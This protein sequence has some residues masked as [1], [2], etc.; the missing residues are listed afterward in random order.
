MRRGVHIGRLPGV[1]YLLAEPRF[2]L[3]LVGNILAPLTLACE[4]VV[5]LLQS[6]LVVHLQ[7]PAPTARIDAQHGP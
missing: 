6:I 1:L 3:A 2:Q 4:R 7:Q 5:K